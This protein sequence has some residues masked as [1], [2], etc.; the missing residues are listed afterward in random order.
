[1]NFIE[2]LVNSIS[3]EMKQFIENGFKDIKKRNWCI[4][5]G[6]EFNIYKNYTYDEAYEIFKNLNVRQCFGKRK[7]KKEYGYTTIESYYTMESNSGHT[8]V[9]MFEID[10][11]IE[12]EE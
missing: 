11:I 3:N 7:Y 2:T 1:M 8:E 5:S 4:G 10:E 9:F 12:K 6:S